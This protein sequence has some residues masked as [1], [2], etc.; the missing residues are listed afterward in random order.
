MVPSVKLNIQHSLFL[1]LLC[2]LQGKHHSGIQLL[3]ACLKKDPS[4]LWPLY[5]LS[6]QYRAL[7]QEAAEL[8]SLKLLVMVRMPNFHSPLSVFRLQFNDCDLAQLRIQTCGRHNTCFQKASVLQKP[9]WV[10]EYINFGT[11]DRVYP[12]CPLF[13]ALKGQRQQSSSSPKDM[14]SSPLPYIK[15]SSLDGVVG[16]GGMVTLAQALYTLAARSHQLN[17]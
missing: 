1:T 8:E 6:T 12:P 13:Q 17:R 14:S 2:N 11:S 16:Q 4:Y 5:S 15:L 7:G 10:T 3:K 9:N